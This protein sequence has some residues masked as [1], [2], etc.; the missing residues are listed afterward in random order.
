[1]IQPARANAAWPAASR[2]IFVPWFVTEPTTVTKLAI[3]IGAKAGKIDLGL[4]SYVP[5]TGNEVTRLASTGAVEVPTEN[6]AMVGDITD[7]NLNPAT[8]FVAASANTVT[9]LTV[10]RASLNNT[11]LQTY[12]C[13]QVASVETLPATATL[14]RIESAFLPEIMALTER[15]VL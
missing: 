3:R 5:G 10:R 9:T 12:G 8:Y 1:V 6:S 14:A 4:Y 13:A 2:A 7:Q 11:L 15:T